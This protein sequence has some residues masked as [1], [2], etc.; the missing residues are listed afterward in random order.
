MLQKISS[1]SKPSKNQVYLAQ[2]LE[3]WKEN[4]AAELL[5]KGREIRRRLA[6]EYEYCNEQQ[7][8]CRRLYKSCEK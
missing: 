3:M 7:N 2:R 1:K 8:I 4:K 5:F 6:K